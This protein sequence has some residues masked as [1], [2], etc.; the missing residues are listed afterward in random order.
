MVCGP[1]I[2]IYS[3][4][5]YEPSPKWD[6]VSGEITDDATSIVI[7]PPATAGMKDIILRFEVRT[8]QNERLKTHRREA[9][10]AEK[11]ESN[12]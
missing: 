2:T 12:G 1:G 6:S 5:K 11:F 3:R 7:L 4:V 10:A 9:E 8:E